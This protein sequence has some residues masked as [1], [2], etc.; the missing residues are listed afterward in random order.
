M[1]NVDGVTL[2]NA[3]RLE[4]PR[5]AY[6]ACE[7]FHGLTVGSSTVAQI[8]RSSAGIAVWAEYAIAIESYNDQK[9]MGLL[10]DCQSLDVAE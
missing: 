5:G 6:H 8:E 7:A 1:L 3:E 4:M 10:K 2:G 9:L